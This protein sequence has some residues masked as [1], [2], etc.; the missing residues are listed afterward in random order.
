MPTSSTPLLG[1]GLPVTGELSGTWGDVVNNSIT[2]LM[3]SAIAGTT[4]ISTDADVTLTSTNLVANESRQAT[5]LFSGARTG[6]RT[7][8]VPA[9]SKTYNIINATTGNFAVQLVATGP[10]V[11]LSI[12][13][14]NNAIVAWNGSDFV[15]VTPPITSPA[16]AGVVVTTTASQTLTNKRITPR[17]DSIVSSATIL[18]LPDLFDQVS[19]TALAVPATISGPASAG[20]TNGQKLILRIKDNGTA[21]ALTWSTVSGAYRVIGTVLPTSTVAGKVLYVGAIYN[22][23]DNFWDVVSVITQT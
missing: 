7:V 9:R 17:N 14:G 23:Q 15:F 22:S 12:A 19:V 5:L 3:D 11:G 4:I 13:A 21:R 16:P 8:T 6:V 20:P 18:P 2:S 10:T 1:L